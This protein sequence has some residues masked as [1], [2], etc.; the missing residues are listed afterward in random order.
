MNEQDLRE[1]Y[2][3][4][5]RAALYNYAVHRDGE[6]LVGVQRKPHREVSEGVPDDSFAMSGFGVFMADRL[7]PVETP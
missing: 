7:P 6:L 5:Y 3:A 4:G 1:A 2:I